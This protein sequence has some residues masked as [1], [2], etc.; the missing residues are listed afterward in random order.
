MNNN[1]K[2]DSLVQ[3]RIKEEKYMSGIS[4]YI[5]E[6]FFEGNWKNL[7]YKV[8]GF[9]TNGKDWCNTIEEA[10]L[11]IKNLNSCLNIKDEIDEIIEET[12]HTIIVNE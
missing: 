8:F 12:Y 9:N 4:R 6:G 5:P 11:V 3:Y 10:K 2:N 1:S 7:A